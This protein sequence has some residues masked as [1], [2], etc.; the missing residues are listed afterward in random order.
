M[1]LKH[2]NIISVKLQISAFQPTLAAQ[3]VQKERVSCPMYKGWE[4]DAC[5]RGFNKIENAK[6]LLVL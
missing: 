2:L 6:S 3:D 5:T 1:D 4:G